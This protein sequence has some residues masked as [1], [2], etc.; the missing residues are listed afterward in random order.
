MAYNVQETIT[1]IMVDYG[2]NGT[3]TFDSSHL[4]F[5]A[6]SL[7]LCNNNNVAYFYSLYKNRNV[8][9]RVLFSIHRNFSIFIQTIKHMF[10]DTF[11]Y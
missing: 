10:R 5:F 4:F 1:G 9:M 8:F 7:A 2:A 11:L 3:K 6:L